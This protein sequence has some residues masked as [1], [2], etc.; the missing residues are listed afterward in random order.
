MG[1]PKLNSKIC[2]RVAASL[3]GWLCI[4]GLALA[5]IVLGLMWFR[6]GFEASLMLLV[7]PGAFIAHNL[8]LVI[9]LR[10]Y[11]RRQDLVVMKSGQVVNPTGIAVLGLTWGLYWRST[12]LHAVATLLSSSIERVAHGNDSGA[13]WIVQLSVWL[14]GV[15]LAALWLLRWQMGTTNISFEGVSVE[16]LGDQVIDDKMGEAI[17]TVKSGTTAILTTAAVIC[18]FGI[19]LLQLAAIFGFFSDYWGWWIIPSFIAAMF[20]A[21]IPLVGSIAGVITAST[22]WHWEW[23]WAALL[24]FFPLAL[25]VLGIGVSGVAELLRGR[26]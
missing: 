3:V 1:A 20:V 6:G 12:I 8:A 26:R 22:V 9:V 24:F 21:Y 19:G 2:Y 4:F 25:F 13:V 5:A 16:K 17:E 23:Y 15:Y 10:R 18:Y 14:T 7:I 11:S